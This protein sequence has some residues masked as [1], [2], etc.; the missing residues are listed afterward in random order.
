[1]Y[2]VFGATG[3]TGKVVAERLEAA[4]KQ[5]KKLRRN[6]PRLDDVAALTQ[7]L[8]GA[9]GAYVMLPPDLKTD[10]YLAER[11][12]WAD[13]IAAAVKAAKVPHVVFLSSLGAQHEA[14]TGP[15]RALHH[16]EKVLADAAPATTFVRAGYFAEN[17]AGVFPVAQKDGVLP[18]FGAIDY[19]FP[20]IA[21]KDIG[22]YAAQALL[23]GGKGHRIVDLVGPVEVSA[24][25]VAAAVGELLGK[26]IKAVAAPLDAIVP[27]FTS[28]GAS[29]DMAGLYHEMISG[30]GKG[31]VA[32]TQP[33]TRGKTPVKDVFAPILGK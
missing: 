28:M 5:V 23:E 29:K 6:A 13:A 8:E 27:T 17:F 18:H 14:G 32:P 26:P 11:K 33:L 20:V 1:M 9:E 15:I 3:N 30:M 25:D 12:V 4:G 16:G 7:A 31:L 19:R 2:V 22:A 10:A 24:E 21:S